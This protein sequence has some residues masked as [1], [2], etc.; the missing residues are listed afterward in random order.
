MLFYFGDNNLNI[1]FSASTDDKTTGYKIVDDTT[2]SSLDTG[3]D[4]LEC[5]IYAN[6]ND[7]SVLKG[8]ECGTFI[9]KERSFNMTTY[10][11]YQIMTAEYDV[12][13]KTLEVYAESAGVELLNTQVSA[14]NNNHSWSITQIARYFMPSGWTVYNDNIGNSTKKVGWDGDSTLTERLLSIANYWN[15]R[16]Y[17]TFNVLNGEVTEKAIH[18]KKDSNN[19]VVEI[20]KLHDEI[21]N[22]RIS[23]NIMNLATCLIPTGSAPETEGGTVQLPINLKNYSYTYTDEKGDVYSVDTSTGRLINTTQVGRHKTEFNPSGLIMRPYS[24]DTLSQE[25]LAG[26]ARAALQKVS[27]PELK[28]NIEIDHLDKPVDIGDIVMILADEDDV[29]IRARITKLTSSYTMN[30][31]AAEVEVVE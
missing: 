17:F 20:L 26:Q 5:S 29:H 19:D 24:F 31:V 7:T 9:L 1:I 3:S 8:L 13:S 25:M 21:S 22:I 14:F 4:I 12:A 18:F 27:Y 2:T 10:E 23:K 16:I 6:G 30:R 15:A 28:Y 11:I